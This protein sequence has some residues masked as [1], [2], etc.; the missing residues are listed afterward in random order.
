MGKVKARRPSAAMIVAVLALTGAL[1]GTAVAGPDAFTSALTKKKV[2]KIAKRQGQ[3]QAN[4]VIDQRHAYALA[5][6]S[7][8]GSI[9]TDEPSNLISSADVSSPTT[10]I[11]CFQLPF[12]PVSGTGNTRSEGNEDGIVSIELGGPYNECPSS[13]EAEVRIVD[14]DLAGEDDEPTYVQFDGPSTT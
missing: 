9:D 6:F 1:A 4:L 5:T 3:K 2:K 7:S 10:G 13:A 14:A 12:D 8:G 11:L